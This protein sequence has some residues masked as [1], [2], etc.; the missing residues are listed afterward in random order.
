MCNV[1]HNYG[2][3]R[4]KCQ[5]TAILSALCSCERIHHLAKRKSGKY[6][7]IFRT[8]CAADTK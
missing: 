1:K 7:S 6:Y 4:F 8:A 5:N 3:M 2:Y